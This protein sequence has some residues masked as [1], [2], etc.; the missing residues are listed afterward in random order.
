MTSDCTPM[1]R[2]SSEPEATTEIVETMKPT[3]M[4]RRADVPM[5]MVS[6]FELKSPI[7]WPD[8]ARQSTVPTAMMAA[9]MPMDVR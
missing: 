8:S 2:P 9:H 6:A 5:T 1:P 7:S 4:M 3:Q